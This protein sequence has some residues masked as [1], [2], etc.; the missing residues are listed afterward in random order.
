MYAANLNVDVSAD[1]WYEA[2]DVT[3]EEYGVDISGI[4]NEIKKIYSGFDMAN[5]KIT[6]NVF[7]DEPRS[8][9]VLFNY[10][11]TIVGET[12]PTVANTVLIEN[13]KATQITA[14]KAFIDEKIRRTSS[15]SAIM[16]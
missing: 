15:W 2:S 1:K 13:N 8:V 6:V 3:A 10:W 14:N 4:T 9:L 12:V 16:N 5:Y 7:A 11:S